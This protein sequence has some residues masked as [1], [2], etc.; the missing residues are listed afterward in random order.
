M[1][2]QFNGHVTDML[3]SFTSHINLL[4]AKRNEIV[5]YIGNSATEGLWKRILDN[6]SSHTS[7]KLSN[8][9]ELTNEKKQEIENLSDDKKSEINILRQDVINNIGL[10]DDDNYRKL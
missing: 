2:D 9:T 7:T 6:I 10:S 1:L 8:I 5:N 3:N 4:N